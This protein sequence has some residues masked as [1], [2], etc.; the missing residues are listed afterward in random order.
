MKVITFLVHEAEEGGYYAQAKGL[1][2]FAEGETIYELKG[3]IQAGINCYWGTEEDAIIH[4]ENESN[5]T[6]RS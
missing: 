4:I 5:I 6:Y 2:I 1:G 3:S